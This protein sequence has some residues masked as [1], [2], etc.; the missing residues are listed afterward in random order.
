MAGSGF[1]LY[2]ALFLGCKNAMLNIS[3]G[4]GVVTE[5]PAIRLNIQREMPHG[6]RNTLLHSLFIRVKS[7]MVS[8]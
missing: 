5:K 3:N 6:L 4:C 8:I 2:A 1:F 7:V